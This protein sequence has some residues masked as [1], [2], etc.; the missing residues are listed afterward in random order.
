MSQNK[1]AELFYF[2]WDLLLETCEFFALMLALTRPPAED[3]VL[4]L[5]GFITDGLPPDCSEN[6]DRYLMETFVAETAPRYRRKY[7]TRSRLRR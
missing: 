2:A 4:E 1:R 5:S 6:F 7:P 3:P